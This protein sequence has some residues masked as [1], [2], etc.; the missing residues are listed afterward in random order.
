MPKQDIVEKS[1]FKVDGEEI[2]GLI[3]R[4]AINLES[5]VVEIPGFDRTVPTSN[6]VLKIPQILLTYKVNKDTK[7][8][9]F[10]RDWLFN[11]EE[12]NCIWERS[13]GT[14]DG[15]EKIDLGW[16]QL[17]SNNIPAYD[18]AAPVPAQIQALLLPESYDVI[19]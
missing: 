15:F 1:R 10:L 16:C 3:A 6:G 8:L 19:E 4:D 13:D 14:G 5:D 7:T 9:K 18:A 2:P 12:K 11:N 17:G